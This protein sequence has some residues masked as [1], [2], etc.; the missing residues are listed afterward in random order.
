MIVSG[1]PERTPDHAIEILDMAF[2]MLEQIHTLRNPATGKTM[3]IRIG[4]KKL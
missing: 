2:E 4:L 1:A 3:R